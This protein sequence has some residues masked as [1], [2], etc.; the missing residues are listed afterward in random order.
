M[1]ISAV[2][3]WLANVMIC[4]TAASGLAAPLEVTTRGGTIP[5]VI[6]EAGGGVQVWMSMTVGGAEDSDQGRSRTEGSEGPSKP[7]E[8]AEES[9]SLE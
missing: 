2:V 1:I 7:N 3:S 8:D 4:S 6:D 9:I 5:V